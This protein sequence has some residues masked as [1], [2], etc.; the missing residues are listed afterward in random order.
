MK[1]TESLEFI[2][3]HRTHAGDNLAD[4]V[5]AIQ[6]IGIVLFLGLSAKNPVCFKGYRPRALHR[7]QPDMPLL[8][9]LSADILQSSRL[10][11]FRCRALSH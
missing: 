7:V 10:H 3:Q 8:C 9:S 6:P 11:R 5:S 2:D 1:Q 4:S